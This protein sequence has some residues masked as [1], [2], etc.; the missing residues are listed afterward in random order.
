MNLVPPVFLAP[1]LA[2]PV[3]VL[4]GGV[5]G[6]AAH[7]LVG[8]LGG[9]AVLYDE[10]GAGGGRRT[11][12][13]GEAGAHRLVVFS[14]GFSPVHP[15]LATARAAGC[16][17]LGELDL[18]ALCWRGQIVAVTGTNG[19]TTLTEFLVHALRSLGRDAVAA[20]NV[21]HAFS[22]LVAEAG[23]GSPESMA[24][25]EASSF[26]TETLQH[27]CAD[28][29]LWTNFAE[30]HLERHGSMA[31]Y[32]FAKWRLAERSPRVFAGPSVAA[33]ARE[34]SVTLPGLTWVPTENRSTDARLH[35]TVFE[36]YP[37]RENFLLAVAWWRAA[38]LDE[39]ALYA[40]A[41][42]FRL[43]AHR[44]APVATHAGVIW[45]NDSKATNFHAAEAALA[46]FAAPVVAIFGGKS[47][48]GDVAAFVRRVAP[49]VQ[50]ACLI[51]ETRTA[52]A[53]ACVA[54]SVAHTDCGLLAA[55]VR[56]AAALARPGGHVLL[57]PGFAS[58]D[59]FNGYA[60]RGT[61]FIALVHALAAP[62][63]AGGAERAARPDSLISSTLAI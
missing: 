15:W 13:A 26:Q 2:H 11:F 23:G 35:G 44:L 9:T 41:R 19:K 28:A 40:A 45:W 55:A 22:Q 49:R 30:D 60:D 18:A 62:P 29:V 48:G 50:H 10:T 52:L 24:V 51:G 16:T 7:L 36:N 54:H 37:Q 38:G 53:A 8:R 58:F 5:S 63:A 14:P 33:A 20:G 46:G 17:C 3:A 21:G 61:Q 47:K 57:S 4:G 25:V 12:A 59:Q 56:R 6:R 27:L 31:D 34:F 43:G 32:F 39:A 1:A 42:T